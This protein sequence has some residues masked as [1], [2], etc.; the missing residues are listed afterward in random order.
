[1][2]IE[3]CSVNSFLTEN[4]RNVTVWLGCEQRG[5]LFGNY[6]LFLNFAEQKQQRAPQGPGRNFS[7]FTGK[8]T[9][10]HPR[11]DPKDRSWF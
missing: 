6:W 11:H 2:R 9:D 1:M 7:T 4:T 8:Q 5:A 10:A 3:P